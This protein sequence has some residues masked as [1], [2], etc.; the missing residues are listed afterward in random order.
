VEALSSLRSLRSRDKLERIGIGAFANCSRLRRI[1]IPLKDNMFP[2][3]S[4]F[5]IYKQFHECWNL[6]TVDLFGGIHNTIS[7]LLLESWKNRIEQEIDRINQ[8]LPSTPAYEKSD[9]IR[10]WIESII[11]S[12]EHYKAEHYALLKEEMAQLELA[13]WKAKLDEKG[14]AEK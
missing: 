2:L 9:T 5:Q 12:I 11:N 7:S 14:T 6:T 10:L 1:T 4:G 13:V 3:D 8:V